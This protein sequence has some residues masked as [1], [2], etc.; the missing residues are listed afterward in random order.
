MWLSSTLSSLCELWQWVESKR[1]SSNGKKASIHQCQQSFTL[2]NIPFQQAGA[3]SNKKR[4]YVLIPL[5]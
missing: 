4:E 5:G 1:Y 3:Q 2:C